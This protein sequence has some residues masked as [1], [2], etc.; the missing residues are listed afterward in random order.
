MMVYSYLLE[1]AS[2]SSGSQ[3]LQPT[4]RINLPDKMAHGVN[5]FPLCESHMSNWA[6]TQ[7]VLTKHD[8]GF[9]EIKMQEL[10]G[11]LFMS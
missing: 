2:N 6:E 1:C 9:H 4:K 5:C 8:L 7:A 10:I 3:H 11:I